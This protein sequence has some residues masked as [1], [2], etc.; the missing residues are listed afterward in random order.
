MTTYS[1]RGTDDQGRDQHGTLEAESLTQ[2]AKQ[3]RE[4][5]IHPRTLEREDWEEGAMPLE[6]MDAFSFFNRSL[7]GLS[8]VGIPLPRAVREISRGLRR[9]RFKKDLERIEAALR[10][11]RPLEEAIDET[12]DAFPPY[13]RW[14][15]SAGTSAGNL[16]RILH[17]VARFHEGLR[18]A[19]RALV[20]AL[21]YPAMVL[22]FGAALMTF[23]LAYFGPMYEDIYRSL[24]LKPSFPR[25]MLLG[26][27]HSP[28][29]P[30]ATLGGM[31]LL[32]WGFVA[33]LRRT[34]SGERL[35]FRLPLVG[36]IARSLV[37]ARLLG[38][39]SVL[40]RGKTPLETALPVALGASGS[41]RLPK[42]AERMR[43]EVAEGKRLGDL[44]RLSSVVPPEVAGYLLVGEE[45][46]RLPEA[47]EELAEILTEQ[48]AAASD[49]M[50]LLLFPLSILATGLLIGTVCVMLILPYF[51]IL[52]QIGR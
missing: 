43:A 38:A 18:R 20:G 23:F 4:R 49:T 22:C 24:Q 34:S 39:L 1:Y 42:E 10:E 41:R 52:E 13:Y 3:L 6:E 5:S 37:V 12:P 44:L 30:V 27:F 8:R 2:A 47:S 33:W 32:T 19:T 29:V 11:G 21:A 25:E 28:I 36:R 26:F 9:G 15:V 48:A 17:A 7:A 14:M 35:L 46:G 51:Q 50:F 31:V 45:S 40:L 16:P